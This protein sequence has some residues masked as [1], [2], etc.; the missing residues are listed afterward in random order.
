MSAQAQDPKPAEILRGGTNAF[1]VTLWDGFTEAVFVRMLPVGEYEA[2]AR[3]LED[4]PRAAEMFCAKPKGWGDT[5]RPDSL[6]A[7]IEEGQ[8]LNADF[9]GPWFRRRQARMEW[10]APGSVQ[11][12]VAKALQSSSPPSA[13]GPG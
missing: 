1:T 8:R 13:S 11:A 6:G 7:L 2:Y 5:L 12:A 10:L 4:E 3:V 9:F